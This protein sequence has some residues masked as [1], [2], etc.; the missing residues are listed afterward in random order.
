MPMGSLFMKWPLPEKFIKNFNREE[1]TS[2]FFQT[3]GIMAIRL[4]IMEPSMRGVGMEWTI[5]R[6]QGNLFD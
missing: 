3:L 6:F 5:Y 1:V 4:E 2:H